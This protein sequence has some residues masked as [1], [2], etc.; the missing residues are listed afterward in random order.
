[1]MKSFSSLTV[2]PP[3]K[4]YC[5]SYYIINGIKLW[6]PHQLSDC[7][8]YGGKWSENESINNSIQ[9]RLKPLEYIYATD[10]GTLKL[11]RKTP[12]IVSYPADQ[13]GTTRTTHG[14]P[15]VRPSN[16]HKYNS[17]YQNNANPL[18]TESDG[19]QG[20]FEQRRT[21]LRF[22]VVNRGPQ[23]FSAQELLA[24]AIIANPSAG[25]PN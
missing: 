6:K 23:K 5:N 9:Q 12:L 11:F 24:S 1:M 22:R 14:T 15:D 7:C 19:G 18:L 13:V 25:L 8:F 21:K 16:Y 20:E 10:N 2:R 4:F 3:V 17:V